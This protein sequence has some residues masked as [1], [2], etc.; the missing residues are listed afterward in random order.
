MEQLPTDWLTLL[1]LVITLGAKHG[2]DADHL[3]AI[4]G[5][6]RFNAPNRPCLARWCGSLFS[7][8]HGAVVVLVAVFV[9][10]VV[11]R[12][13]VPLW[14][15]DVGAWLSIIFLA[16]LG[17]LN[18]ATVLLAGPGEV[19]RAV[20]LKGR[21]FGRLQ[22]TSNPWL[23][24]LVGTLFA[25]SFDTMTQA[26]LFAFAGT[27]FGGVSH[28][29]ALGLVFTVGMLVTDGVN[30]LWI[31]RLIRRADRTACIASRII[32]LGI[33]G[34][35][36]AVAGLGVLKHASPMV[37]A[38]GQGKEVSIGMALIAFIALSFMLALRWS[39]AAVTKPS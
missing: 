30:G 27:R 17:M 38:W 5:L 6:T 11:D 34:I 9:G 21:I 15:E 18:I 24:A 20:G 32:G 1:C 28:A 7:L 10:A 39:S 3:A 14:M 36:L 8:G 12:W 19:V 29:L 2:L 13:A 23:I 31:S 35:S 37:A 26:A 4:D 25:L 33:G 22:R 16:L